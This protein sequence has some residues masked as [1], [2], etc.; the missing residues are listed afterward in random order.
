MAHVRADHH[1]DHSKNETEKHIVKV[2]EI[3]SKY[4]KKKLF[5]GIILVINLTGGI[6]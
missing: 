3:T 6:P 2:P 5:R 4:W 1:A